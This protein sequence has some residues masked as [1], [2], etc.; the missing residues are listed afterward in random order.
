M[1]NNLVKAI[2]F[3]VADVLA[4]EHF[5]AGIKQYESRH[6]IPAG[7]LYAAIHDHSYWKD[8]TLGKIKEGD[9]FQSVKDS[10]GAELDV[11]ELRRLILDGLLPNQPLLDFLPT[12]TGR[13]ILGI[14]SNNPKE[15]FDY[16]YE[17]EKLGK[18]FKIK[19]VSGYLG[20]RKPSQEIFTQ[21][22]KLAGVKAEETV[23]VDDR[24]EMTSEA[25][26]LGI[27]II[28]YRGLDNFQ[29]ELKNFKII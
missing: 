25:A 2:L 14:V 27:R 22:L 3:D 10:F 21:A 18:I 17:R 11:E 9:Y 6:Q 20:V 1:G 15:W 16:F 12:L 24:P 5:T 19:A 28:V 29:A 8:F 23:Y 7:K 26:A 4:I 13:Y